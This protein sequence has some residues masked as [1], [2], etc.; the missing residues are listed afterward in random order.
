MIILPAKIVHIETLGLIFKNERVFSRGGN[1]VSKKKSK[2]A[3]KKVEDLIVIK[4]NKSKIQAFK[5]KSIY[6]L[7]DVDKTPFAK[8]TVHDVIANLM[9]D[10]D[11]DE[12][13]FDHDDCEAIFCVNDED[14]ETESEEEDDE[15]YICN[16]YMK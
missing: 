8:V 15:E 13:V 4:E 1:F 14:S 2:L 7:K 9:E 3:P 11:D 16:I 12:E 6:E 10:S 5:A